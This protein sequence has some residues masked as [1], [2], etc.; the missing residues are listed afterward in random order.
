MIRAV[1][2]AC[3]LH[4]SVLQQIPDVLVMALLKTEGGTVGQWTTNTDGSHDLG[5]MQIND[6]TWLQKIANMQFSGNRQVAA[7]DLIYD[8][9]YN[10]QVGAYIF[11]G[12]LK[13]ANGDYGKAIGFYNSHTPL[14]ADEYRRR[15]LESLKSLVHISKSNSPG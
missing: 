11:A 15:F 10:V 5:P 13:D 12:Y 3:I 14:L 4:A 2:L 1:T 6:R 7:Q 8:G 9:C